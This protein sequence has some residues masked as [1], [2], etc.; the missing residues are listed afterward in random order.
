M[1]YRCVRVCVCPTKAPRTRQGEAKALN[2]L[3][4]VYQEI[5][6]DAALQRSLEYHQ[7]HCDIADAAG[8]FIAN[9]NMGLITGMRADLKRSVEHHKQALQFA[10]RAQDKQAEALALANLAL[11]ERHQGDHATARVCI[12]RNLELSHDLKDEPGSC[13]AYEQLGVLSSDKK[14]WA[15]ASDFLTQALDLSH[16]QG[17]FEKTS[18]IR[19]RLGFVKGTMRMDD[20]FKAVA[21]LM[22]AK[23]DRRQRKSNALR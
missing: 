17:N 4:I 14:D 8:V 5:G 12:E 7:Q 10:V 15:T 22:G 20:H 11:S 18:S 19:C 16:K 13:D 6:T 1:T 9:T 3:G 2:C 21:K 23:A